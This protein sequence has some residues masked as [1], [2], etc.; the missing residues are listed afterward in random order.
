MTKYEELCSAFGSMKKKYHERKDSTLNLAQWLI[1]GFEKYLGSPVKQV[2]YAPL[3]KTPSSSLS[4]Y[5]LGSVHLDDNSRWHFDVG[6]RIEKPPLLPLSETVIFDIVVD[7]QEGAFVVKL[8]TLDDKFTIH[9]GNT[10]EAEA[11]YNFVFRVIS[12]QYETAQMWNENPE[13]ERKIGPQPEG[14]RGK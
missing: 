7:R 5:L 12:S 1:A 10:D 13:S 14:S 11:F 4:H 3:S 8:A 9:E 2:K 6:I